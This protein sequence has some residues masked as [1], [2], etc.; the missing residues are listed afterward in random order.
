MW[1]SF[2]I[3]EFLHIKVYIFTLKTKVLKHV[4]IDQPVCKMIHKK[5]QYTAK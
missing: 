3:A 5:W 2:V 4:R 1:L